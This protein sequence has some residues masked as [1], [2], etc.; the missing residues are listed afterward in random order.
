MKIMTFRVPDELEELTAREIIALAIAA[1]RADIPPVYLPKGK[2]GIKPL[3]PEQVLKVFKNRNELTIH[4][5]AE[6]LGR[7]SKTVYRALLPFLK[8][9]VV[10]ERMEYYHDETGGLA[11]RLYYRL[12]KQDETNP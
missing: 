4:D 5:M 3:P 8:A 12:T 10:S 2:P 6:I 9:K 7:A 11:A 1:K